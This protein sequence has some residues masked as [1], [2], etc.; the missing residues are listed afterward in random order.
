M[1]PGS[2]NKE[3]FDFIH[4]HESSDPFEVTLKEKRFPEE[5]RLLVARQILARQKLRN[6]VP[7][8]LAYDRIILPDPVSVEQASSSITAQY[9]SG[10]IGKGTI[11]DLS[12]GLG[13]DAYFFSRKADKVIYVEKDPELT[14]IASYN[15][16]LMGLHN[17]EVHCGQA[18]KFL[19][20]WKLPVER[21][22]LD[23]SRR[24]NRRKVIRLEDSAPDLLEIQDR[25]LLKSAMVMVKASPFM[26]LEYAVRKVKKLIEFHILA[27]D[28]ECKEILMIMDSNSGEADISVITVNYA[29]QGI[30]KYCSS[31][32][33]E[34]T[35]RCSYGING[36]YLYDPNPAVRKA[37][38]FRS[39]CMDFNLV[40]LS[41]NSHLYFGD[42]L[43]VEFP[44]RVF[45]V[46]ERVPFHRF[47]KQKNYPK[48]NVAVR[49]FPMSVLEIRKKARIQDGGEVFIFGT[50]D[51]R[52]NLCFIIC[53]K[54]S[55]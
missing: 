28:N 35:S 55:A 30:Q 11:I 31:L 32:G 42:M 43:Q 26:D 45:E 22:F 1:I 15:F 14:R 41:G 16:G 34:R 2:F 54:V 33:R 36:R 10:L 50:T 6:K 24:S 23:P 53:Q 38:L 49:N 40:K 25:M 46:I 37:G 12:G 8:W 18:E 9:K 29:S 47:M 5:V 27:V 51:E 3:I 21:M 52:R 44:G 19:E 13:I 39:L 17:I 4:D 48:A 20:E 7:E